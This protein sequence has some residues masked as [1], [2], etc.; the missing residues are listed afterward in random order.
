MEYAKGGELFDYICAAGRI[1]DE[2]KARTFFRQM[3]RGV[4]YMHQEG[5]AHR[6]LKPENM[7]FDEN[8]TIKLIDLGLVSMPGEDMTKTSCGS[9]N[10]AAPEVIQGDRYFAPTGDMWSLGICLYAMLCGFLPFDDPDLKRLGAKIR[11]GTFKEPSHLSAD[12]LDLLHGLINTNPDERYTME[13]V[14]RHPWVLGPNPAADRLAIDSTL[15]KKLDP[16]IVA[17]LSKYYNQPPQVVEAQ[18]LLDAYDHVTG[19]YHLMV[20]AKERL[21]RLKLAAGAGKWNPRDVAPVD[22]PEFHGDPDDDNG[23]GLPDPDFDSDDDVSLTSATSSATASVSRLSASPST[24]RRRR[25]GQ[26][27]GQAGA[28]EAVAALGGS[29]I[30]GIFRRLSSR[31]RDMPLIAASHAAYR[32]GTNYETMREVMVQAV[33]QDTNNFKVKEGRFTLQIACNGPST[34]FQDLKF[35]VEFFTISTSSDIGLRLKRVK[36]DS[37]CYGRY[38]EVLLER[39]RDLD[40]NSVG[41]T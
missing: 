3:V 40:P 38:L 21:Q 11:R 8:R 1:Q 34:T 33:A 36:G 10:Y 9:A 31:S 18:I 39:L 19:D 35:A 16:E 13:K 27:T 32:T 2:N 37:A 15:S 5:F 7:L 24:P 41:Q 14:R 29:K 6:D 22:P 23:T 17:V 26:T 28:S 4:A 25:R 30:G 12:A 20:I